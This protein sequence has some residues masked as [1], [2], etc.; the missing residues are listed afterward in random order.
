[1]A[2]LSA[3]IIMGSIIEGV[4]LPNALRALLKAEQDR[5]ADVLR[6]ATP[7]PRARRKGAK[8]SD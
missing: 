2:E 8:R 3:V 6:L 5:G 4:L 1:M 7:S